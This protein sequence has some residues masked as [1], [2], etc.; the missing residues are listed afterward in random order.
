VRNLARK[1]E[2]VRRSRRSSKL[3]FNQYDKYS[4]LAHVDLINGD[5][6]GASLK[7]KTISFSS[8]LGYVHGWRRY[9]TQIIK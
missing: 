2:I 5:E 9:R 7:L 1:K 4:F 6:F 3:N 8:A